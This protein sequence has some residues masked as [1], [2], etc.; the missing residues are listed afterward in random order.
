M[1]SPDIGLQTEGVQ[2]MKKPKRKPKFYKGQVVFCQ[3][4]RMR[5]SWFGKIGY[6]S[7]SGLFRLDDTK[8]S[9]ICWA[10]ESELRPL[11]AK[12]IGPRERGQ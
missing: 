6:I 2:Q 5:H 3:F 4:P 7:Q 12:E 10:M 8:G 9:C 1:V 11:T